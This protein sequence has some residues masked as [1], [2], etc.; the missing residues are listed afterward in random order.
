M[1]PSTAVGTDLQRTSPVLAI[2]PSGSSLVAR[3]VKLGKTDYSCGRLCCSNWIYIVLR[4]VHS[5]STDKTYLYIPAA[6]MPNSGLGS[7]IDTNS[8]G[9]PPISYPTLA[10][11]KQI[12]GI[13][14]VLHSGKKSLYFVSI[15]CGGQDERSIQLSANLVF[16]VWL[17]N[18]RMSCDPV[19]CPF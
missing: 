10:E 2:Y 16:K 4:M 18:L 13:M 12:H 14:H 15:R 9:I 19:R 8:C 6:G 11:A 1:S 5:E 3:S 17:I 7:S